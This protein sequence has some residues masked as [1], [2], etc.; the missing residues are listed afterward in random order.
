[1]SGQDSPITYVLAP[2]EFTGAMPVREDITVLPA[3][4]KKLRLGWVIY[5]EVGDCEINYEAIYNWYKTQRR[6]ERQ[7]AKIERRKRRAEKRQKASKEVQ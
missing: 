2:E 4:P 6:L 1:M 5:E 7:Q 3:E